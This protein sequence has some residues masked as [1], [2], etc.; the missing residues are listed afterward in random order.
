LLLMGLVY[1]AL[2]TLVQS[3]LDKTGKNFVGFDNYVWTFTNPEGFW[4]VIN[5]LIWVLLAPT[6]ATAIGLA[7]AVF[8][9]RAAGEKVLKVLIFMPFAISFVGAGIIW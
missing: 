8:I 7:Y 6:F 5:T 4:S 1:P 9:D 3:F 2:S